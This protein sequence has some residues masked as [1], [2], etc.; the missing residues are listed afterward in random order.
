MQETY[1]LE[2]SEQMAIFLRKWHEPTQQPTAILQIAHGMAEHGGRYHDFA[3]WLVERG[4]FVY[5]HDHRG[6][7]KTGER[8]ESM[9]FFSKQNGFERVVDDMRTVTN[10]IEQA[11]PDV[12]IILLG[13][14]MGSFLVR[15]Y[16]QRFNNV[17][18]GVILSGTSF[19][20]GIMGK[21]GQLIARLEAKVRGDR[22][23][24]PLLHKLTFGSFERPFKKKGESWLS[25]DSSIVTTYEQDPLCGFVS[26]T[27]FYDDLLGGISLIHKQ[28]EVNKINKAMP[29]FIISGMSDPVGKNSKGV[30]QVANSYQAAGMENVTT[31]LYPDARHEIL[32]ETNWLEVYQ[33]I[34]H[35]IELKILS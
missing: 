18:N 21:A 20:Q 29:L 26:S 15:R 5:A 2:N 16:I 35:W 6:H 12:P 31:K 7:G 34:L 8:S 33:D 19:D 14:S 30:R 13:H 25:R 11:H 3:Q 24:S 22:T 10:Q 32:F 4:I 27:R 17:V 23:A 1:W 9:G 28:E